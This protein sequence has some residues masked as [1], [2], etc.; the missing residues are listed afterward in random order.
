[1]RPKEIDDVLINPG[2]GFMTF[3]K[4]NGGPINPTNQGQPET[5]MDYLRTY[6]NFFEPRRGEYRWD[7]IES[8]LRVAHAKRQTLMFRIMS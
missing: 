1:M 8:A 2:I 6:W 4:A 7:V 5:S 3:H